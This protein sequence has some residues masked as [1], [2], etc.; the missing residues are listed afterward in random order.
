MDKSN[1]IENLS[2]KTP[3]AEDNMYTC[4][5]TRV[6]IQPYYLFFKNPREKKKQ[7]FDSFLIQ[8]NSLIGLHIIYEEKSSMSGCYNYNSLKTDEF[9]FSTPCR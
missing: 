4:D 8:T 3:I 2:K 6:I 5:Y 9:I 1:L 7:T